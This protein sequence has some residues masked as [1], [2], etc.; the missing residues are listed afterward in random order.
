[1]FSLF[2][3]WCQKLGAFPVLSHLFF[4]GSSLLFQTVCCTVLFHAA[5]DGANNSTL[6]QHLVASPFQLHALHVA[7]PLFIFVCICLNSQWRAC[8][9][10]AWVRR[11]A[12]ARWRGCPW[13]RAATAAWAPHPVPSTNTPKVGL[14]HGWCL[15][16]FHAAQPAATCVTFTDWEVCHG[17]SHSLLA[18]QSAT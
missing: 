11:A 10:K 9:R 16:Q 13:G 1:M 4:K 3:C 7:S 14:P 2:G 15:K 12:S 8:M 18:A 17:F 5:A 6:L